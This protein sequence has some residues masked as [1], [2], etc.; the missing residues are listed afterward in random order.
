[1]LA[2]L[3]ACG[4][5]AVTLPPESLAA[6]SGDALTDTAIAQFARDTAQSLRTPDH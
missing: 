2:Q 1:M 4:A 6:W 3:I 5:A